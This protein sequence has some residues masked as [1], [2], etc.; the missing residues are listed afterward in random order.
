M[1]T[2]TA[3]RTTK[4]RTEAAHRRRADETS[5]LLHEAAESDDELVRRRLLNQVVVVNTGVA[6]AIAARY[7]NRGIS[8]EDLEQVAMVGLVKASH[9]YDESTGHNFLSY[10]VPTISGEVR[11]HFR[12]HGW[13]VRPPRRVQELQAGISAAETELSHRLGRSP[14]PSEIAAFLEVDIEEVSEALSADGCFSP[15]SLD[16]P[17]GADL[18]TPLG[19]LLGERDSGRSSVEARA[20]LSPVVRRLS[21]RDRH[22]LYLRFFADWTQ[23]QI[24]DDIGVTQMQVSRL[25]SRILTTLRSE[26]DTVPSDALADV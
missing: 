4:S 9:G 8:L 12:D 23:Q 16:Q 22:I 25:L 15:T 5:R 24:A 1:S 7:R 18:D 11:R 13:M 19:T 17:V 2:S 21:E 10:A 14:R 3:P 26:L 20:V 6:R